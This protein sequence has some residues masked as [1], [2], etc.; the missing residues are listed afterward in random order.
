MPELITLL[1]S[2][3]TFQI[4][5]SFRGKTY[6]KKMLDQIIEMINNHSPKETDGFNM[7]KLK[8]R[9]LGKLDKDKSFICC[10]ERAPKLNLTI[11]QVKK[12]IESGSGRMLIDES[13]V[14]IILQTLEMWVLNLWAEI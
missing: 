11:K 9:V 1:Q 12:L 10:F 8:M 3:E 6:S 5:L 2:I 7:S 4:K 13:D 14:Q